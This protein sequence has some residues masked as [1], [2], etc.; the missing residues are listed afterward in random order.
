MSEQLI[1]SAVKRDGLG[2][3]PNRRLREEQVIPGVFY[4]TKGSNIA[5]QME[6]LPLQ[7]IFEKAGRTSVFQLEI[8]DNGTKI[9]YPVLIWDT[10]FHPYKKQFKHIDF[11]GVDLE[12]E[13]KVR[14]PLEFV[15]TSRGVKLGGKLEI[16]REFLDIMSKPMDLPKKITIDLTELDVNTT[17]LQKDVAFPEGVRP[18]S[19]ENFAILSVIAPKAE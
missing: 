9:S 5:I 15:G 7:K 18:A 1:L 19:K 11:F 6:A 13:I 12:K 4:D 14:I 2:K 3:G 8:D 10:L 16:Y 17:I